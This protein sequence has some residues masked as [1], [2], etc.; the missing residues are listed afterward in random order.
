MESHPCKPTPILAYTL[1]VEALHPMARCRFAH[2]VASV[3][4]LSYDE[5][6]NEIDG[7]PIAATADCR[8]MVDLSEQGERSLPGFIFRK[9]TRNFYD[10]H[11]KSHRVSLWQQF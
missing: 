5:A 1:D 11:A 7:W 4:G 3:Y 9:R 6:V 10:A 8:V 2:Y